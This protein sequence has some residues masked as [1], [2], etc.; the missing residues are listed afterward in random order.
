MSCVFQNID[1]P[2]PSPPGEFSSP[3]TKAGGTHSPG[4]EGGGGVNISEDV[5][6]RIGLLQ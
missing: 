6:H 4:G 1:L 5:R 3:A 2:P